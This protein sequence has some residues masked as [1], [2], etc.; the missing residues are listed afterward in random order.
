MIGGYGGGLVDLV[1][2]TVL[3]A[4]VQAI[5]LPKRYFLMSMKSLTRYPAETS[6]LTYAPVSLIDPLASFAENEKMDCFAS[7]VSDEVVEAMTIVAMV[8]D[9]PESRLEAWSPAMAITLPTPQ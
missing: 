5:Q 4:E 6:S 1:I 8:L 2:E 3:R 9:Q 7:F